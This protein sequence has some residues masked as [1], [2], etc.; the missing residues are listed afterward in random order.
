MTDVGS[1]LE[2]SHALLYRY[3]ESKEALF[4]LALLYAMD[5]ESAGAVD[6]PV[7]TPT[8]GHFLK[9]VR[10]WGEANAAFPVLAEATRRRRATDVERE[11]RSIVAERYDFIER[12]RRLLAL[13][14]RSAMD[15][16][17]L[18]ALYFRRGRRH[19]LEDLVGYLRKRVAAG[20]LRPV[21]DVDAA[22]R[23]IVESIAWFA[24]HRF[25]D[26]DPDVLDDQAARLTVEELLVG[27]FVQTAQPR[28][29][30]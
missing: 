16:P 9:L 29:R 14:E 22:A 30:S 1:Q 26:R 5:P 23:F 18:H 28:G 11:F 25:H 10:T 27:A 13:L 2:L 17:E 20:Q 24:W 21:P 3:V 19:Q 12:N 6:V 4:E 8:P 7:P 15:L